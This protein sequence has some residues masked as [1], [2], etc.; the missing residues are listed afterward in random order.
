MLPK[1]D[2]NNFA[3]IEKYRLPIYNKKGWEKY[4]YFYVLDP[5]SVLE[6]NPKLRRIRKK[7]N[8]IANK[9]DRDEAALRFRDEVAVKLKQGWNPLIQECGKKGFTPCNVVF[10]R[11]ELN[12]KKMLKDDVIKPS[13]YNN[14]ICRLNQ[15]KEW[16]ESLS[17]KMVYI[18]Q[19]DRA[20]IESFL[21]HY[22]FYSLK[23][24]GITDAID[25]VG[26]SV[27]K[28]QARHSSV[29]TTNKYVRKEQMTAHQEL[30]NF[31]GN[32]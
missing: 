14:Y 23:D 7:F 8:H 15:L 20:Y 22:Q 9:K 29:A 18:Y 5:D 1:K 30:K 31:E 32:L 21:E 25:R 16:N 17:G 12:M 11:Y 13:T 28:D 2:R 6:G 19:F 26:L 24:T 4:V 10:E 3:E 27:A